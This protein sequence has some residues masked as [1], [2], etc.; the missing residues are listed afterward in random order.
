LTN[1]KQV[2]TGSQFSCAI[3]TD[4][5]LWAW[6]RN[7]Y[8]QLGLGNLTNYSSPKQIGALTT[9]AKISCA[10]GGWHAIAI[11]TDGTMWSWGRNEYGQLGTGNVTYFSSPVQIGA[12]TTWAKISCGGNFSI[13]IKTD[14]TAWAWG[15]GN[16]G[17]RGD[18][19]T[20]TTRNSPIQIGALTN[21]QDISCGYDHSIAVKTD[22]TIWSWGSGNSGAL[23]LGNVNQYAS[24]KQIGALTTWATPS[25]GG[26]HSIAIKTDGTLWSWGRNNEGQLGKNNTTSYSSPVQVGA[27]TTWNKA[28]CGVFHTTAITSGKALWVWGANSGGQLG[29]NNTTYYSSPKQ[30]GALTTWLQTA[31][32]RYFTAGIKT[33]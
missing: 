11:K 19:T 30:V 7:E 25:S 18:S 28:A 2:A 33:S 17:Q 23:G 24:P 22:G 4:G 32:G 8:G 20:T 6:G 26:I 29:L 10:L 31:G 27:L 3:K 21:W 16:S 13:A 9:W 5:T 14:G 12:L 15:Q 1:W